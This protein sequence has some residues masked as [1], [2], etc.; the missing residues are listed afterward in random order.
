MQTFCGLTTDGMLEYL[1]AIYKIG[2]NHGKVT[3]SALAERM[4]VSAAAA[5]SMLKRLEESGFV[6]RSTGDGVK[7]TEQGHLAA[8]QLVR[9]HRL[10][11]VFLIQVMGYTWDQVDDEAHRL[12]HAISSNFEDRMDALCG[13]PTHCPH[14]DPI[15]RK[16]GTMP[17]EPLVSVLTLKP[18]QHG[19]LRRVDSSDARVLRYLGQL[20]LM[21]G[22]TVKLVDVAPFNG[23]VTLET[24]SD[25]NAPSTQQI[26]GKELADKLFVLQMN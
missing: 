4:H 9:R 10:L 17:A 13:Y 18:G 26:L 14:G 15:P 24:V 12:Q 19:V 5:S 7:L 8:M 6:D 23:P 16:D 2:R 3:T 1:A 21:P 20:A 25:E 22:C 11:E